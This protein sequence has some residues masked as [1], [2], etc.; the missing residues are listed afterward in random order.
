[1]F[2]E[3]QKS[4]LDYKSVVSMKSP[5]PS[6]I[7]LFT[8]LRPFQINRHLRRSALIFKLMVDKWIHQVF[9]GHKINCG[10]NARHETLSDQGQT[11]IKSRILVDVILSQNYPLSTS[12]RVVKGWKATVLQKCH[13]IHLLS[14]PGRLNNWEGLIELD[15]NNKFAAG[16]HFDALSHAAHS[17]LVSPDKRTCQNE[18]SNLCIEAHYF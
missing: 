5:M 16:R 15:R 4:R 9:T 13:K 6:T 14:V 11:E 2:L 17:S 8:F 12:S 18:R 3:E 1:M 10:T 7:I